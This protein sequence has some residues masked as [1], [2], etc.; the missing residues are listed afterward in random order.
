MD[1][2]EP[3]LKI[4][5][6]RYDCLSLIECKCK[7]IE[8]SFKTDKFGYPTLAFLSRKTAKGH[9]K[10]IGYVKETTRK[11]AESIANGSWVQRKN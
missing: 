6:K 5:N 11:D 2:R 9:L 3:I 4:L 7:G 8:L 1:L 10:G